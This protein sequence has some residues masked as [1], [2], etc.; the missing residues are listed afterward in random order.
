MPP[1]K[2]ETHKLSRRAAADLRLRQRGHWDRQENAISW[3]NNRRALLR[4]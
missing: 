1:V 2:F 3:N 4:G